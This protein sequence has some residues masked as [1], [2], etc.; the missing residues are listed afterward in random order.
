[1]TSRSYHQPKAPRSFNFTA[2]PPRSSRSSKSSAPTYRSRTRRI[3]PSHS[4]FWRSTARRRGRQRPD[5]HSTGS[6]SD[7]APLRVVRLTRGARSLPLPVLY[8]RPTHNLFILEHAS[9]SASKKDRRKTDCGTACSGPRADRANLDARGKR[10]R[11]RVGFRLGDHHLL[12]DRSIAALAQV[13]GGFAG[14]VSDGAD[15]QFAEGARRIAARSGPRGRT[16][17]SR[18]P[19]PRGADPHRLRGVRGDRAFN[20]LFSSH[21]AFLGDGGVGACVGVDSAIRFSGVRLSPR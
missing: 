8:R 19:A 5:R 6:G 13:G 3:M 9:V 15:D 18:A 1:M 17:L 2:A 4:S 20:R 7:L 16:F 11:N 14:A 21:F 10:A 12:G